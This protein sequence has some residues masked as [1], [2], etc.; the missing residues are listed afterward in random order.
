MV[1]EYVR[2]IAMGKINDM[3]RQLLREMG[4]QAEG[5]PAPE[6]APREAAENLDLEGSEY[7]AA[8][9]HL[10]AL[11]DIERVSNSVGTEGHYRLTKQGLRRARAIRWR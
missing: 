5:K 3:A 8:L 9:S 6:V 1:A 11:G 10:L 7:S 4:Y 2:G